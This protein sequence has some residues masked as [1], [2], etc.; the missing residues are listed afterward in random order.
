MSDKAKEINPANADSE[1]P[2]C[3]Y[4]TRKTCEY[5]KC[6]TFLNWFSES[7]EAIQMKWKRDI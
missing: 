6:H 4:C 1:C 5:S 2:A 3:W 7:W